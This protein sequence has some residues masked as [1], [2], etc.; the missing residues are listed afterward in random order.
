[1]TGESKLPKPVIKHEMDESVKNDESGV[2]S[3]QSAESSI[4]CGGSG[5]W[6]CHEGEVSDP[7][8]DPPIVSTNLRKFPP[9]NLSKIEGETEW[10]ETSAKGIRS[11]VT[12]C[13]KLTN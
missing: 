3:N 8:F 9:C 10:N 11:T 1:M 13:I 5:N 4:E 2:F 12:L 6:D 7:S